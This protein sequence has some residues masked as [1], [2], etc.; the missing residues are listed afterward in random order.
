MLFS[1][2]RNKFKK[3]SAEQSPKCV[4]TSGRKIK[5]EQTLD[6]LK[7]LPSIPTKYNNLWKKNSADNR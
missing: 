6:G 4:T 2:K 1:E 3:S 7:Y 5:K